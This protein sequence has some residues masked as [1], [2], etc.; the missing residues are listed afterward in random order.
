MKVLYFSLIFIILSC[1]L[2]KPKEKVDHMSPSCTPEDAD[3]I[4]EFD[5]IFFDLNGHK[6]APYSDDYSE[7][8]N[9]I[10]KKKDRL[11]ELGRFIKEIKECEV[12]IGGM[13]HKVDDKFKKNLIEK[14]NS[15]N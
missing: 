1:S 3:H 8:N 11:L 2:L 14:E 5:K 12:E 6:G 7:S 9:E 10:L 13:V 4:K 15:T